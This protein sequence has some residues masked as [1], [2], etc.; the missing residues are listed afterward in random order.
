MQKVIIG[1]C[2]SV[3][4]RIGPLQ[5]SWCM[6]MEAKNNY[7]KKAGRIGN[8]KNV[9]YSVAKRHQRLMAAYL[10]GSFFSYSELECACG[11]CKCS[12]LSS[13]GVLCFSF[14]CVYVHSCMC[15]CVILNEI[16]ASHIVYIIP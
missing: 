16:F 14:V 3:Y 4:N 5:T 1:T 10:Q 13:C 7:F 2:I 15:V 8:F 12:F 11:P 9:P 6:R